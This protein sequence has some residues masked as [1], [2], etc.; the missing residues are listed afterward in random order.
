MDREQV[1]S[2]SISSIG[3]EPGSETL[4]IEFKHGGIYRYFGVPRGDHQK[5]MSASSK[6]AAFHEIIRARSYP[7]SKVK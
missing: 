6:G 2:D 3:Y 4:E 1:E 7:F 5:L